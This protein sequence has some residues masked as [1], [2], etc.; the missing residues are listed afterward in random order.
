MADDNND[1]DYS[2]LA[3]QILQEQNRVRTNPQ[4]YIDKLKR[5]E[6]FFKDK[7]FRHP[8][9]IPIETNEGVNGVKDAINFLSN[10]NPLPPLTPSDELTQ[11]AQ[12][13]AADIGSKGLST[14][15]GSNGQG[16]CERIERY[17][18]WDGAIAENLE[19]C[20]K[21]AENIVMNLII[22]DG[23][24]NKNQRSNLFDPNFKFVGVACEPHKTF[25]ICTVINYANGLHPIGEE[26]TDIVDSIQEYIERTK[27][28]DNEKLN[29]FQK[30]D[31]D[32]P[33]NTVSVKIMKIQKNIKGE[34]KGITRKIYLLDNGR[35]HIVEVE[36][37]E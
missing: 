14:H 25:K 28:K 15:E 8:A 2:Q 24:E 3:Q 37:R 12:D 35:Q 30:D 36:D 19:F 6:N 13:H 33:D 16:L 23:S 26:P 11:A 18:E 5:A 17:T 1:F 9:E 7:I 27:K 20:Y 4:S 32:A 29:A 22:D 21:F 34:V 10:L 31:L